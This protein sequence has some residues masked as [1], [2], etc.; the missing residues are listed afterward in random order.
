M[1]LYYDNVLVA[2]FFFLI[3]LPLNFHHTIVQS[4]F[5]IAWLEH[6][7]ALPLKLPSSDTPD[8]SV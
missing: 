5:Q 7:A 2:F 3:I 1:D 4:L 8:D 6:S